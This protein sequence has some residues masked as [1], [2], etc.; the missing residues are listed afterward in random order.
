METRPSSSRDD[1]AKLILDGATAVLTAS[2]SS[3]DRHVQFIRGELGPVRHAFGRSMVEIHVGDVLGHLLFARLLAESGIRLAYIARRQDDG[4]REVRS[5]IEALAKRD[6]LHLRA[7]AQAMGGPDDG[8]TEAIDS[9]PGD[10]APR[11]VEDL[12]RGVPM[13]G[14]PRLLFRSSSARVHPGMGLRG[15]GVFPADA[16]LN[17]VRDV[18]LT[19]V[20]LCSEILED[21]EPSAGA[22][23]AVD[24]LLAD[25]VLV[26][27]PSAWAHRLRRRLDTA[28]GAAA[29][30]VEEFAFRVEF[31][32]KDTR[33]I[34]EA[35]LRKG[36]ETW[37]A[38][39]DLAADREAALSA[40]EAASMAS[41]HPDGRS[42][43]D[44]SANL[45]T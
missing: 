19:D 36:D 35:Q 12:A 34:L 22:A 24:A 14:G 32:G 28:L 44:P 38:V 18:M 17:K 5:A 21:L 30:E 31:D 39:V 27:S 37:V 6:L 11:T 2:E 45:T 41:G 10:P 16:F 8:I 15:L 43:D 26:L 33:E 13:A 25:E 40:L 23:A 3:T 9:I 7:T 29:P 1:L 4:R 20:V 42:A